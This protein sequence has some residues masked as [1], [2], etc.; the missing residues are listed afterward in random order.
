M[1]SD[2]SV[3]FKEREESLRLI[4]CEEGNPENL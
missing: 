2:G 4:D 3:V 1:F